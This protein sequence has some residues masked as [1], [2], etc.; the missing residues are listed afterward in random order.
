VVHPDILYAPLL[1]LSRAAH[2]GRQHEVA[3]HALTAAMHAAND[4]RDRDALEAIAHEAESQIG[5]IDRH[6]SAQRL[7]TN[8]A[9]QHGHPGVYAMLAREAR[10]H[11]DLL[12]R[13]IR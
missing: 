7:S 11:A 9:H 4:A 13:Q 3:Y 8:S 6:T 10:L 12:R 5:W 1:E 2:A